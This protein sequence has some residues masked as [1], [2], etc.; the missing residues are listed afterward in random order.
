MDQKTW[1][2]W[3]T[4]QAA[5]WPCLWNPFYAWH[6][7]P[8]CCCNG[9]M[10]R[11]N[12]F[13]GLPPLLPRWYLHCAWPYLLMRVMPM[14]VVRMLSSCYANGIGICMVMETKY[15]QKTFRKPRRVRLMPE[16]DVEL[17]NHLTKKWCTGETYVSV[18]SKT[19]WFK[20]RPLFQPYMRNHSTLVWER[21]LLIT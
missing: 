12:H 7:A 2:L 3:W 8:H 11:C 15:F 10:M 9:I 20:L 6:I 18:V 4:R 19:D 13:V 1:R 17:G 21:A 16:G 14:G 5:L